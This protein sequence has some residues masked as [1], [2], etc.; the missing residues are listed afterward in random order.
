MGDFL[1]NGRRQA[2]SMAVGHD[3]MV[4]INPDCPH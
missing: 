1:G 3:F 2:V 4:F